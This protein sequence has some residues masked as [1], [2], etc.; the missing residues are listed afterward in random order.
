MSLI[1]LGWKIQTKRP[2]KK[3]ET[4]L[5]VSAVS[6]TGLYTQWIS[7]SSFV[8]CRLLT[9]KYMQMMNILKPIAFDVIHCVSQL[10]DYYLYAV[11]TFFGRNDMVWHFWISFL[12]KFLLYTLYL[13]WRVTSKSLID[14]TCIDCFK[15]VST[16]DCGRGITAALV[17]V[18]WKIQVSLMWPHPTVM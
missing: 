12:K 17:S 8:F 10:F 6:H 4:Q 11:Y 18:G 1:V 2:K 16:L 3:K 13:C 7:G 5:F 14:Y 9:G 15:R